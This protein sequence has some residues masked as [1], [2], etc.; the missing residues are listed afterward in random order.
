MICFLNKR[1]RSE[2]P[3]L[4]WSFSLPYVAGEKRVVI[5]AAESHKLVQLLIRLC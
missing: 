5:Y 1:C 2:V 4:Q 3:F